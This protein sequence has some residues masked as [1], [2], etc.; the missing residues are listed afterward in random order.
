MTSLTLL[1]EIVPLAGN[2]HGSCKFLSLF[3]SIWTMNQHLSSDSP[4][5]T[6]ASTL[7]LGVGVIADFHSTLS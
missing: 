1:F 6:F 3:F 5:E 4:D 2:Y 7:V